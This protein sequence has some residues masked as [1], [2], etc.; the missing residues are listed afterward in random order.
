MHLG[1]THRETNLLI[2][3]RLLLAKKISMART[4]PT[5]LQSIELILQNLNESFY[6]GWPLLL[7]P[8][9]VI[10][11]VL[12]RI[13]ALPALLIGAIVGG[14]FALLFQSAPLS[15]IISAAHYGY[16]SET[17][18]EA[19]DALL[20]RGGLESMMSTV[21]LIIFALSFGGAMEK[22]GMLAVIAKA[23]L[24][25]AH[26]SGSIVASTVISCIFLNTIAGDQY[27]AIIVPGRMYRDAYRQAGLAPRNL[28]RALED[29]GTLTSALIPWNSG[30]AYMWATLGVFPLAYL[31]FAFLNILNPVI[32]IIYGFTGFTM[33]RL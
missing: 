23:I 9:F 7:P 21:A 15:D 8:V 1:K 6:I 31:P 5:L 4:R 3:R 20:S 11:M 2:N 22:T 27:L 24:K 19:V 13:P 28:S 16:V 18:F 10:I 12:V 17:G 30:G 32:S 25:R 26:H 29:G 14:V 33:K